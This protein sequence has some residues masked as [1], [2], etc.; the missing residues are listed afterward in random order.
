MTRTVRINR[1]RL[2]A[3]LMELKQIGA[4]DDQAAG[5]RGVRRLALTDAD[6]EA[7]RQCVDWMLQ[8]KEEL[9]CIGFDGDAHERR[10]IPHAYI[11]CHI[12]QGPILA[13]AGIGIG[14]GQT[15]V[16][17]HQ[18]TQTIDLRNPTAMVFV[19]GENRGIS[20]TPREYSNPGACANGTDV[21]ASAV[22]HP[23]DQP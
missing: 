5:P 16:I 17:P 3:S 4:H 18:A 9:I 1:D 10:P 21:L 7:R 13:D 20:H 15:N 11:E 23:A 8:V 6:A 14:G 2:W 19:A 22:L 12:E